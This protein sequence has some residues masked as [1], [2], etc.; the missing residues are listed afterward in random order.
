MKKY[1]LAA[2]S[3]AAFLA[4]AANAAIITTDAQNVPGVSLTPPGG[5]LVQAVGDATISTGIDFTFGNAEGIF[6]D[7]PEA[8]CGINASGNCDL[9]TAVDGRIV[10]LGSLVQGLTSYF[11]AEAGN[12]ANGS[13]TLSVFDINNNLL[14]TALNGPPL[15][16]NGRTTFEITRAAADIAFFSIGGNDSF[17]VNEIRIETP[18]GGVGAVPEPATWAFMILGFGAIGGAM[19]RQRKTN[20]KVSY[21]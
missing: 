21:A 9:V 2:A 7:P 12:A 6:S 14:E 3:A 15:G 18:L 13:L 16:P 17:G 10:Q 8:F 5:A 4:P 11:F 20:V 1:L 19:R